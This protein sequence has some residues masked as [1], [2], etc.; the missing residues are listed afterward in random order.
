MGQELGLYHGR[1]GEGSPWGLLELVGVWLCAPSS[2]HAHG[3]LL[4]P[5]LGS[6]FP[7]GAC[8]LSSPQGRLRLQLLHTGCCL[9]KGFRVRLGQDEVKKQVPGLGSGLK[10][11]PC[12]C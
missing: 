10:M 8:S 12:T 4:S 9:E 1:Q 5:K 11:N 7:S 6:W 2:P 3:L